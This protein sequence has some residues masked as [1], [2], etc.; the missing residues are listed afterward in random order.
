[1]EAAGEAAEHGGVFGRHAFNEDFELLANEGGV[2]VDGDLVLD[3]DE[4]VEPVAGDF[5]GDLFHVGGGGAGS[6]GVAKHESAVE[7]ELFHAGES[8]FEL[9]FGF[10]GEADDDVGGEA[11][12]GDGGAEFGDDFAEGFDGVEPFHAL[13]EVVMTGLERHVAVFHDLRDVADDFDQVGFEIAGVGGGVADALDTGDAAEE[14]EEFGEGDAAL[15][16]VFAIRV[17]RLAKEANFLCAEFGEAS[18]FFDDVFSGAG[19][20]AA[21]GGGHDAKGT[22]LVAPVLDRNMGFKF[23]FS[24]EVALGDFGNDGAFAFGEVKGFSEPF[25]SEGFFDQAGDF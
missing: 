12:I 17:D 7:L 5:E 4:F 23:S 20:F 25:G 10:A 16:E 8:A 6:G 18:G 2:F 21:P 24:F 22:E 19:A 3:G 15:G 11:D 9:F 14:L 1:M 13:E